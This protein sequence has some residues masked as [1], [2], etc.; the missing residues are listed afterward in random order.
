MPFAATWVVIEIVT[1]GEVNQ[2]KTNATCYHLHVESKIR[3]Q[4]N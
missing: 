1:L 4:V 2:A 3:V